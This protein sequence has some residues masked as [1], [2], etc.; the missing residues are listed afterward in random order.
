M[1]SPSGR[2]TG[3]SFRLCTARSSE[4]SS[5]PLSSSRVNSP[6]PPCSARSPVI[7]SPWVTMGTSS[8]TSPG[9]AVSSARA[10]M[11]DCAR[12]S[13]LRRVPRRRRSA[14][15]AVLVVIQAEQL[16]DEIEPG[17]VLG[18]VLGTQACARVMEDLAHQRAG[19]PLELLV[20]LGRE[21]GE[22]LL[23]LLPADLLRL[24][25][26]PRHQRLGVEAA[27]PGPEMAELLV[28]DFLDPRHLLLAPLEVLLD[29]VVQR[30]DGVEE[31]VLDAAGGG[32]DVARHAQV[33]HQQ[34][35]GAA[36]G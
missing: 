18:A 6:L 33:D 9:C 35:L 11:P 28:D 3:R 25:L 23:Q 29:Q 31:D 24:L 21:A 30:V 14:G 8:T 19:Q 15:S 27:D 12:A 2:A 4:P 36:G 1:A 32:L 34:R 7:T 5:R 20:G 10:I 13:A 22:G 17:E 26:H 16:A